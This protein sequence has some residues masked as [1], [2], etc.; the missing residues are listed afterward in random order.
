MCQLHGDENACT[1]SSGLSLC[2]AY[3]VLKVEGSSEEK[4]RDSGERETERQ[5]RKWNYYWKWNCSVAGFEF[6]RWPKILY[7]EKGQMTNEDINI[8]KRG[9]IV[10]TTWVAIIS[11]S[12]VTY[13]KWCHIHTWNSCPPIMNGPRAR[14]S[15]KQFPALKIAAAANY[16]PASL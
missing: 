13:S 11:P 2:R 6:E 1:L 5:R 7:I 8:G 12:V 9:G 10:S 14:I 4:G 15:H 3:E 16:V